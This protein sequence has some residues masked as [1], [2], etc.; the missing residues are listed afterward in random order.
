MLSTAGIQERTLKLVR[1]EDHKVIN[2]QA[3]ILC[4]LLGISPFPVVLQV[5]FDE[6]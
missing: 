5:S 1:R 3:R 2:P 4:V 6:Q